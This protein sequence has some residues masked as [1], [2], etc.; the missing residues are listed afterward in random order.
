MMSFVYEER[1]TDSPF[2]ETIWRTQSESDG[3]YMNLAD[4]CWDLLLIK[5]AAVTQVFLAG[6]MTK[7]S[8]ILYKEGSQYMAI[9]F[10]IGAFMPHLPANHILDV[11]TPL[12]KA[13]SQSFWLGDTPWQLPAWENVEV[14]VEKLARERLIAR[15]EVVEAIWQGQAQEMSSRSVQRHFLQTTGLTQKY[16]RQIERARH[17]AALLQ[18]GASIL[19]TV[20]QAGYFDQPH[21]TKSLKRLIGQTPAQIVR[22]AGT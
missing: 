17:A 5:Q 20:Y 15:D 21:L 22:A 11:V 8:P 19:E 9:R 1:P 6:P 7:A 12:P 10:K 4:G 16:L 14:F 2:V 13:T 3:C 18:Q